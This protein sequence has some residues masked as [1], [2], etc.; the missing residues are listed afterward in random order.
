MGIVRRVAYALVG[1][2]GLCWAYWILYL[3]DSDYS[4]YLRGGALLWHVT[5]ERPGPTLGG[6]LLATAAG[7]LLGAGAIGG[8]FRSRRWVTWMVAAL[9]LASALVASIALY[10]GFVRP[11]T[12]PADGP[13][14]IRAYDGPPPWM[15][16][17]PSCR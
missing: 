10:R 16:R 4:M 7:Y 6:Y 1:V 8:R 3:H 14:W 11:A 12:G 17:G 2:L 9:A 15:E 13:G 5:V